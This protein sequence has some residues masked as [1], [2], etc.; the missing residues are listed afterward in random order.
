MLRE[1]EGETF[2]PKQP[3]SYY[4]TDQHRNIMVATENLSTLP[5]SEH[6]PSCA[7]IRENKTTPCTPLPNLD[8]SLPS[9]PISI[10]NAGHVLALP[11]QPY[12][13]A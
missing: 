2:T 13:L 11:R 4:T 12:D 3:A 9:R 5:L 1:R 7:S 6:A 10:T 8:D